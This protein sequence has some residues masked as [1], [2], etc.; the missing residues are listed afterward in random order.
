MGVVPTERAFGRGVVERADFV[1]DKSRLAQDAIA[2]R[3]SD[4]NKQLMVVF[5]VQLHSFPFSK[6]GRV[7]ADIHSDIENPPL[8]TGKE[9]GLSRLRLVVKSAQGPLLRKGEVV[10]DKRHID[11]KSCIGRLSVCLEKKSSLV[12]KDFGLDSL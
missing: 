2:V 4:G 9:L 8:Q 12:E 1:M 10:L 7:G 11:A 3:K 6:S 5:I